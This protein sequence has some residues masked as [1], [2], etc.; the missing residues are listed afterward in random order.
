LDHPISSL[1]K[2]L[3][4]VLKDG[5]LAVLLAGSVVVETLLG[6]VRES[7]RAPSRAA[8][9]GGATNG[10]G[11]PTDT[12]NESADWSIEVVSVPENGTSNWSLSSSRATIP[13]ENATDAVRVVTGNDSSVVIVALRT[14]RKPV[15]V[16]LIADCRTR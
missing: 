7:R 4:G 10:T 2:A 11:D 5:A 15:N 1:L 12:A 6:G 9:P 13:D 3:A 8:D 14:R 16:R